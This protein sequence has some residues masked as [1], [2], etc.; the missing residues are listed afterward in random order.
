VQA[1]RSI[2]HTAEDV[3]ILQRHVQRVMLFRELQKQVI[4]VEKFRRKQDGLNFDGEKMKYFIKQIYR[5]VRETLQEVKVEECLH[6]SIMLQFSDN[7]AMAEPQIRRDTAALGRIGNSSPVFVERTQKK[8]QPKSELKIASEEE[9]LANYQQLSVKLGDSECPARE[10]C[11]LILKQTVMITKNVILRSELAEESQVKGWL[12]W[13]GKFLGMLLRQII[14][15][16]KLNRKQDD[17]NFDGEKF[18]YF[19]KQISRL[20]R[21]TLQQMKLEEWQQDNVMRQFSEKLAMAEPQIRR[22]TTALGK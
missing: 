1:I 2:D 16:E 14:Q 3:P 8:E 20:L 7:I 21:E 22:D 9:I 15:D 6:H 4:Q 12:S 10:A 19:M 18:Q 11:T 5:L 13:L 17:L